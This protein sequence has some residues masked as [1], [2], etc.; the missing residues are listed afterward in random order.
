MKAKVTPNIKPG[1][2]S[3]TQGWWPEQ[4]M[5]GHHQE[6]THDLINPAQDAILGSN[7]ALFDVR[8]KVLKAR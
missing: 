1:V 2:V 8:V 7:A 6:L 5:E 3:L 4:Y